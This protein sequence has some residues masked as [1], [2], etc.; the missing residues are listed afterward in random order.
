M[1]RSSSSFFISFLFHLIVLLIVFYIYNL[2][3]ANSTKSQKS[4]AI[5]LSH[6]VASC[7]CRSSSEPKVEKEIPK[8]KIEKKKIEKKVVVKK[9]VEKKKIEKKVQT[10]AVKKVLKTDAVKEP[11]EKEKAVEEAVEEDSS[12]LSAQ[13]ELAQV[14]EEVEDASSPNEGSGVETIEKSSQELYVEENISKI[15]QMLKD[16]LYY[17]TRARKRSIEGEVVIKFTLLKNSE[18]KDVKIVKHSHAVLDASAVKTINSLNG[19]L[20]SPKEAITLEVPINYK[21]H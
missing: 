13:N 5:N 19:K 16:N 2:L 21:L 7:G 12:E 10:T 15:A 3:S 4:V 18:I 1:I 6:C 9:A 20:P 11:A 8:Q 14:Q 17:P